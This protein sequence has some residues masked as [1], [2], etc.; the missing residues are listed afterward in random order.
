MTDSEIKS[1]WKEIDKAAADAP[2]SPYSHTKVNDL[3]RVA[4]KLK[5]ENTRLQAEVERVK[6]IARESLEQLS[7]VII[8]K[9]E[10]EQQIAEQ[11]AEVERL[12]AAQ[13]LKTFCDEDFIALQ[14]ENAALADALQALLKM[15]REDEASPVMH[16]ENCSAWCHYRPVLKQC[17]K[18]IEQAN[19][20]LAKGRMTTHEQAILVPSIR[21][22]GQV[23]TVLEPTPQPS[24]QSAPIATDP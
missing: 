22:T 18:A 2:I 14:A 13:V 4:W 7:V 19:A 8:G 5:E 3:V 16:N 11:Q 17:D 24:P 15:V 10:V 12:K 20:A 21:L 23:Q 1:W 6:K 9:S